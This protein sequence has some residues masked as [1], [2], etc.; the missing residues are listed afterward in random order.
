MII[1]TMIAISIITYCV[2]KIKSDA[3]IKQ[4]DKI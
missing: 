3:D 1:L 4:K 2:R